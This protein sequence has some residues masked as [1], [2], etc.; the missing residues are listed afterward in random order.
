MH[1]MIDFPHAYQPLL[2]FLSAP[3]WTQSLR[4]A[5][6]QARER[7]ISL[8][9]G[10]RLELDQLAEDPLLETALS[11]LRQLLQQSLET[12][13]KPDGYPIR[14]QHEE[15]DVPAD[16]SE[17]HRL[18][19]QATGCQL[20]APTL[21]GLR[22][23]VYR[24]ADELL[25]RRAPI[26]PLR[27]ETRYT[28]VR[29]RIGRSPIAPYRWLSGWEL[30]QDHDVYPD[31]YLSQLAQAGVNAIWA[32]GLLRNLVASEVI[33]EL[34]PPIHRLE[35]L[36]ALVAKAA[37]YGIRV[38]L[39]CM[40]PRAIPADHPAGQAHPE[41]LGAPNVKDRSLCGSSD[42]VHEFL[43]E[44]IASLFQEVPDLAGL[45]NIP[46]GERA[47]SCWWN[48]IRIDGCP[49]CRE[50][51][52]GELL[53]RVL[54]TMQAGIRQAGSEAEL[55]AWTYFVGRD[56]KTLPID[57]MLEVM[58]HTDPAI[59]WLGNFEHGLSRQ[60]GDKSITY[61]EYSL[62]G[63]GP[64]PYYEAMAAA[65]EQQGAELYAKLQ[66]GTTFEMSS[67]PYLPVPGIVHAKL[68][69]LRELGSRGTMLHWIPGGMPNPLL[70]AA[71]EAA[72]EPALS[73]EDLLHRLAAIEH[74]ESAA[75]A[76]SSAWQQFGHIWQQY[77]FDHHVL[78]WSPITRAPAYQLHLEREER[79][80]KPYNFGADRNREPQPFEDQIDRW[81]GDLTLTDV[82]A[83]FRHLADGWEDGLG[84]LR[85]ALPADNP[86]RAVAEAIRLQCLATANICEFYQLRNRL[87]AEPALLDRLI[88]IA[89]EEAV[90]TRQMLELL[91]R[92]PG[93]GFHSELFLY[94][95]DAPML[96]AK[97]RQLDH[98]LTTLQR[99][100][101]TGIDEAVLQRTVEEAERLRPDNWGD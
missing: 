7:E 91:P 13:T 81:A 77:P 78:Y 17:A 37:R 2:D 87:A 46:A 38:Y 21:E 53:G 9:S 6:R 11:D 92:H 34:G 10:F 27:D 68:E 29:A 95:Y 4:E 44:A 23:A 73:E 50:Q 56:R 58:A 83:S 35:R 20:S 71:C 86:D 89:E 52:R 14:L 45:I 47:T 84:E 30:E 64:S 59:I 33:P 69:A 90:V 36:Q 61:H 70:Q 55:I 96:R 28:R 15:L 32:A 5:G 97:L 100:Q 75:P 80:A 26:L 43:R 88:E 19:I 99:W 63:I 41:I 16:A 65:T 62:S 48:E 94:S 3:R 57:P 49:I 31:S 54:N 18:Q 42:L 82:I 85:Q 22:R 79:L 12:P 1:P 25:I 24:L 72:F 40:E 67:V 74:G 101:K 51:P 93:L 8:T 39:F 66:V 76:V 98:L 60:V